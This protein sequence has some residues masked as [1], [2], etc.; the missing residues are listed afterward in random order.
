[1]NISRLLQRFA[2]PATLFLFLFSS[3]T[4]AQNRPPYASQSS[5]AAQSSAYVGAAE[6]AL[7]DATNRERAAQGLP[8]LAWD[9][10]LASAAQRHA[11]RMAQQHAISHQFPDEPAL[12]D[13]TSQAGAHFSLVAENVAEGPD[14]ETIHSGWMHSAGHRANILDPELTAIGIAVVS[15]G[16]QLYAVQDFAHRVESLSLEEQEKK[17]GALLF[18]RGLQI[19]NVNDDARRSCSS[20]HQPSFNG[21]IFIVRYEATDIGKLPDGLERVIRERK[22][23]KASVGACVADSDSGF[24]KYRLA[25]LLF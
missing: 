1:M 19:V 2:A 13:R 24:T 8:A 10:A 11:D 21:S 3:I 5:Q 14:P 4:S 9:A 25:V 12:L 7:L 16:R 23:S 17:V 22:Y 6:R 20:G 18:S 15:R